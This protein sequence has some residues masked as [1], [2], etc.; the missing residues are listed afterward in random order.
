MSQGSAH[1]HP[2]LQPLNRSLGQAT[3]R[4][5][6]RSDEDSLDLRPALTYRDLEDETPTAG[7]MRVP[8]DDDSIKAHPHMAKKL[9]TSY[10]SLLLPIV[11]FATL[12]LGIAFIQRLSQLFTT[13]LR[14]PST[15]IMSPRVFPNAAQADPLVSHSYELSSSAS[16]PSSLSHLTLLPSPL[17][18]S[19]LV[20]PDVALLIAQAHGVAAYIPDIVHFVIGAV[21]TSTHTQP[22]AASSS[23]DF[24]IQHWLAL[25]SARD[26]LRPAQLL[27]HLT[28]PAPTSQWWERA[29]SLCTRVLPVRALTHVFGRPIHH[30]QHKSDFLRLEALLQYGGVALDLDVLTVGDWKADAVQYQLCFQQDFI[31]GLAQSAKLNWAD[32]FDTSFIGAKADSPLLREWYNAYRMFDARSQVADSGTSEA[33][34]WE[35][36]DDHVLS[37]GATLLWTLNTLRPHLLTQLQ[38]AT[39]GAPYA[40]EAEGIQ[41]LY[42]SGLASEV[43]SGWTVHLWQGEHERRR[44]TRDKDGAVLSVAPVLEAEVEGKYAVDG[45]QQ[46]CA[47]AGKSWYGRLLRQSMESGEGGEKCG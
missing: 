33:G 42:G 4:R 21:H 16:N 12:L 31:V 44:E 10:T 41:R 26:V 37:F 23:F 17:D 30:A 43:A 35:M 29:K 40:N 13:S 24:L 6:H 2:T 1:Y 18:G 19:Q 27:C 3:I 7:D 8:S 14:T 11:L 28:G 20:H 36:Y 46:L 15:V 39:V 45:V 22:T 25:K 34:S 5:S 32:R 9:A 38:P 47:L